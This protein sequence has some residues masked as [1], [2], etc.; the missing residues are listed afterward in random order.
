MKNKQ[1]EKQE[2]LKKIERGIQQADES[3][4][5]SHNE[6]AERLA[7]KLKSQEGFKALQGKI[8]WQGDLEE[9]R[10]DD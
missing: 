10:L 6:V 5:L 4:T 1:P 8:D 2:F 9:M 3:E 7:K